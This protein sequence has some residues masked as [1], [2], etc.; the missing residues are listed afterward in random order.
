MYKL[1][2]LEFY[3]LKRSWIFICA[4][5]GN[6][7][8]PFLSSMM[9]YGWAIQNS[10]RDF[11]FKDIFYQNHIFCVLILNFLL[12]GLIASYI[13]NREY[14]EKT[15]SS[16]LTIPVSRFS[17]IT[18]KILMS[19][20]CMFFLTLLSYLIVLI[21]GLIFRA[22]GFTSEVLLSA[23]VYYLKGTILMIPCILAIIL[24]SC[25]SKNF[26]VPIAFSIITVVISI[27]V[28]NHEVYQYLYPW[29]IPATFTFRNLNYRP[30][31]I[32]ISKGIV[33]GFTLCMLVAN[34]GYFYLTDAE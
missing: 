23:L 29:V 26:I 7:V 2:M 13:I 3:K 33:V 9:Y 6:F 27:F 31:L 34:Y 28:L 25:I 16:I 15:I 4:M 20:F 17:Y 12:F 5:A 30:D 21:I 1:F 8:S 11:L 10:K 24:V 22:T 18:V 32:F 19:I 14:Q